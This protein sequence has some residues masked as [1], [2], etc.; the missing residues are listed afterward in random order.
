MNLDS[1]D[2]AWVPKHAW[3]WMVGA[4]PHGVH[5]YEGQL[6]W[7]ERPA[8]PGGY[9]GEVAAAQSFADFIRSG[10]RL[11]APEYVVEA[12]VALLQRPPPE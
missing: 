6:V 3:E 10:P 2:W 4:T 8:G 7:W 5:T 1:A 11:P 12:V 9:F